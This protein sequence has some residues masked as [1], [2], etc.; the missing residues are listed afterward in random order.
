MA[1]NVIPFA[2]EDTLVRVVKP[3]GEPWFVGK[4]VC[5]VLHIR[6]HHQALERLDGDERGGYSVPTPQG[7]QSVICVSEPGVYRLIFTSRKPEAER[8]KRWLAHEVLPALRKHGHYGL[9][10]PDPAA[11]T[12]PEEGPTAALNAKLGVIR[13]ARLLFGPDRARG[14]WPLLGLPEVP[15]PPPGPEQ[16]GYD[17]LKHLLDLVVV[18]AEPPGLPYDLR[19]LLVMALED[20]D[21]DWRLRDLGIRV[22]PDQ[23]GFIVANNHP[24]LLMKLKR[25][26]WRDGAHAGALRRLPGARR[27]GPTKFSNITAH[28]GTFVPASLLDDPALG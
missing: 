1:A 24:E 6:D 23:D 21:A 2:F 9:E 3:N 15:L 18:E 20:G 22:Y 28:R 13:E 7:D 11:L 25:T 14:L 16:D 8:F 17:C 12:G 5:A 4:D 27:T 26:R 10:K 19:R